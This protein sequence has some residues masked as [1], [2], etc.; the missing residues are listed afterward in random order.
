M[1][2]GHEPHPCQAFPS[3]TEA[4]RREGRGDAATAD[5]RCRRRR[6]AP[7]TGTSPDAE[8]RSKQLGPGVLGLGV[9]TRLAQ[10]GRPYATF[11]S[12]T[13]MAP[14]LA[15]ASIN[16]DS[17]SSV[18]FPWNKARIVLPKVFSVRGRPVLRR[19]K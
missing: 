3:R 8:R 9:M 16:F 1:N 18:R 17:S 2:S 11:P 10:S 19:V 13:E 14:C 5:R 15:S 4:A 6:D 12:C 7:A